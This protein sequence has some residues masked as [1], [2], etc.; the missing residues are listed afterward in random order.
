M[1]MKFKAILLATAMTLPASGTYAADT[2]KMIMNWTADSAH[3]GFAVAQVNGLYEA[4]D[5]NVELEEGRGSAVAAAGC[6]RTG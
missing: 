6:H 2:M 4:A 3:L 1:N 5:L